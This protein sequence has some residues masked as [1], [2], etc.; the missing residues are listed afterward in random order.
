MQESPGDLENPL[1]S[2]PVGPDGLACSCGQR[3]TSF[4]QGSSYTRSPQLW[5]GPVIKGRSSSSRLVPSPT[6]DRSDL[7][8]FFQNTCYP[9]WFS[10]GGDDPSL[11]VDALGHQWPNMRLY[12]FPPVPLLQHV[13]SR[14]MDE[15]RELLLVAPH[16]PKRP[17]AADLN[18]R[19][20]QPSL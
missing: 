15:G 20:M 4:P 6:S 9:L 10:L 12:A 5:C 3:G 18:R 17:W 11:G 7:G 2:R 19:S 8:A 1:V 13:L 16:W 14:I